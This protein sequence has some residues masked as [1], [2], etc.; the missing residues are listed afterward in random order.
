M[1]KEQSN[2][3]NENESIEQK[4]KKQDNQDIEPQR[5]PSKESESTEENQNK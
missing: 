1:K 3:T 5:D 2:G 4:K